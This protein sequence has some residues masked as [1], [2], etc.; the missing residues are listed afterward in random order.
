[1]SD[2]IGDL[3]AII[4]AK[5]HDTR[6]LFVTDGMTWQARIADFRKIVERQCPSGDFVDR[7]EGLADFGLRGWKRL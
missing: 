1:M 4:F 3:D 5:R 7:H 6:L 2:I